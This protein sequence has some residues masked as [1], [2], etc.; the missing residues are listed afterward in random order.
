MQRKPRLVLAAAIAAVV[1]LALSLYLR[2]WGGL[3]LVA[4]GVAG[5]LWYRTQVARG[6]ASDQFFNDLGEETRLTGLQA[7]SPSEMPVDREL[8]EP[9][10]RRPPS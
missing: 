6:E 3:A 10:D 2:S 7:G 9:P 1:V 4:V 5:Y 8:A